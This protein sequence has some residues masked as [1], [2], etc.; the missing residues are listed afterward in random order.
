MDR[1][2]KMGREGNRNN[3][4]CGIRVCGVGTGK[5][6]CG[7]AGIVKVDLYCGPF[8]SGSRGKVGAERG[9]RSKDGKESV[10]G[11]LTEN[12]GT[13]GNGVSHDFLG[14]ERVCWNI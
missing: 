2:E 4:N 7:G 14:N 10:E 3:A 9:E 5:V 8:G 11:S 6:G 13:V 12:V 1:L